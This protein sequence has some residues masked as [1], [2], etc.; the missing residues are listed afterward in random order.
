MTD[1]IKQVIVVRKDLKMQR[2]KEIA[3]GSHASMMFLRRQIAPAYYLENGKLVQKTGLYQIHLSAAEEEWLYNGMF[4]KITLQVD[5]EAAFD[6]IRQNALDAGL[7]V[8]VVV[9]SGVT[10]FNGIP[11]KTCLAIGPDYSSKIDPIT[12]KLK[13]Y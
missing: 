1:T 8:H 12:S 5:S 10:V 3:Q 13:L 6:E 7:T 11:T 4:T 2:G 9:D